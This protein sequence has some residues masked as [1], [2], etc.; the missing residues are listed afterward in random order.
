MSLFHHD[1]TAIPGEIRH[2]TIA[3]WTG[4]N[5]AAVDHH[6]AELAAIGV[7]P[8]SDVPLFY[9]V[10]H[11]LLTVEP[12]IEVLGS[13]SSGEVEPVVLMLNG[14]TWLGLG[15]DHTDRK[16][17]AVSVAASKQACPKP[18]CPEVWRLSEVAER[19]ET[20]E[21]RCDIEEDGAWVTYQQGRL[22]S[23]LP[24]AQLI[25]NADLPDGSAL[26]CGTLGALGGIRPSR[27]YRM[28]LHDP[29]RDRTL[30]LG[31]HVTPLPVI[32]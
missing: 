15:S 23:L 12:A 32:A 13:T 29:A 27:A 3:G 16:L 20:L 22:D 25:A 1:T 10:S 19:L 8:P 5:R 7:A 2:L 21:L 28:S 30:H 24:L 4:R 9:R 11:T 26:F 6:I 17:E 18:V 14:E 31:Y